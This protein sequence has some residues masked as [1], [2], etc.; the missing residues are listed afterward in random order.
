MQGYEI[1]LGEKLIETDMAKTGFLLV[2]FGKPARPPI[3]NSHSESAGPPRHRATNASAAADQTNGFS[4]HHRGFK[5]R[6]LGARED[7]LAH[8]TIAFDDAAGRLPPPG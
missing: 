6:R 1:G 7:S 2:G 5:I 3:E 4:I 8:Q